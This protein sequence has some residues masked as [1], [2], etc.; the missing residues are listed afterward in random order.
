SSQLVELMG[1]RI[2]VVSEVGRGSR[3]SFV[4]H[5]DREQPAAAADAS[6]AHEL[7][8]V[9]VLVVDDNATTRR[10]S[11]ERLASWQMEHEA[12]EG[13]AAALARLHKAAEGGRPYR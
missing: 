10:I 8:D 12:V 5:F 9:A 1:G 6:P 4:A 3:F 13:A 7:H 11:Q 2:S